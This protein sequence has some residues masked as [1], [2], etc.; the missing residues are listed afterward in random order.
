MP[1]L[2]P[3]GRC[4]PGRDRSRAVAAGTSAL[5]APQRHR[6][7]AHLLGIGPAF[8]LHACVD[9]L[10]QH[11]QRPGVFSIP[12]VAAALRS[13]V[14]RNRHLVAAALEAHLGQLHQPA[15]RSALAQTLDDE[16]N[17]ELRQKWHSLIEQTITEE[18]D[19]LEE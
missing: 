11:M 7:A 2:W 6:Y 9:A 17:E 19:L 4:L 3:P 13:P 10:L 12:I 15:I 5:E 16:V 1:A 14:V 8:S 18:D